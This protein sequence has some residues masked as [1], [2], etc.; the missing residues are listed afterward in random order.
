MIG[1]SP[2]SPVDDEVCQCG[3][4]IVPRLELHPTGHPTGPIRTLLEFREE[5]RLADAA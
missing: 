3:V 1:G 5:D 2:C 4:S